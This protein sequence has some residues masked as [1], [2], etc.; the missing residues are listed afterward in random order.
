MKLMQTLNQVL[1][2]VSDAFVWIFATP[3][4]HY[5]ATGMVPYM[6]DAYDR[7]WHD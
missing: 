5:P 4:H 7:S 3:E 6:G 2:Y 1:Q